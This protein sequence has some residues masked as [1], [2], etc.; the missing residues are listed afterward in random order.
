MGICLKAIY[1]NKIKN[2]N[3]HVKKLDHY[4]WYRNI[5]KTFNDEKK[6]ETQTGNQLTVKKE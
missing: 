5:G 1:A 4:E 6:Q 3:Y 2:C